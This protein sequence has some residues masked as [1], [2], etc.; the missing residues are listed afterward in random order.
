VRLRI[1]SRRNDATFFTRLVT[2]LR[3]APGVAELRVNPRTAGVLI[4]AAP[5]AQLGE[6]VRD[7]QAQGLFHLGGDSPPLVEAVRES[8][9]RMDGGIRLISGNQLDLR[10]LTFILLLGGAFFQV[11]RGNWLAPAATLGWYAA[12]VYATGFGARRGMVT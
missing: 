8:A 3:D 5:G 11:V 2:A 4:V 1:P 7:A 9:E 12:A 6:I 10:A